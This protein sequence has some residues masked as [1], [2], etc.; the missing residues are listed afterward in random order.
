MKNREKERGSERKMERSECSIGV[1]NLASIHLKLK[2]EWLEVKKQEKT[3][4]IEVE[5]NFFLFEG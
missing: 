5:V 4:K 3:K 1:T 2:V